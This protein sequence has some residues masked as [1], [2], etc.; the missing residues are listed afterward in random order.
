MKSKRK[1]SEKGFTLIELIMVIVIL[2]IISAVA[3]PKFLSLSDTAKINAAQGIGGG[4]SG[5]ISSS[6]ADYLL[7]AVNYDL[8]DVL[9]ATAF[10]GGVVYQPTPTAAPAAG[11]ISCNAAGSGGTDVYLNYKNS[12]FRWNYTALGA[13]GTGTPGFIS[14]DSTSA[15]P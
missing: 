5:T 6:H 8:D 15:F 9:S 13:S 11:E 2:G 7:N 3:I 12:T 14:Q 1:N 10:A 4:I